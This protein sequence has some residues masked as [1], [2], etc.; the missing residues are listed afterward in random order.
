M[1]NLFRHIEFLLLR[2]DCVIVPGLGAFIVTDISAKIDFENSRILPPGR[3]L[4]FNQAVTFDD[5]LL[6]NSYARYLSISFEEARQVI[7][8]EVSSLFDSLRRKGKIKI[9]RLGLL[10]LEEENQLLF[11]PACSPYDIAGQM[12]LSIVGYAHYSLSNQNLGDKQSEKLGLEQKNKDFGNLKINKSFIRFTAVFAILAILAMA[13]ILY[14]VPRDSREQR[15]SVVPVEALISSEKS[16]QTTH[17]TVSSTRNN[18]IESEVLNQ[19]EVEKETIV[20]KENTHYMIVATFTS[21]KEAEK[22]VKVNS[23][24][25]FPLEAISS[26]KLTRVSVASSDNKQDL[27]KQLKSD[28]IKK[29]YPTAW[30]WTAKN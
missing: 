14:P 26:R 25:E 12:G 13:V 9:G 23:T 17:D 1:T 7:L 19:V 3:S 21:R 15:A 4:M 18:L 11:T 24:D 8:K 28:P 5:G 30:I 6:A 10:E 22:Y 27:I 2:H 29:H 20:P 16:L